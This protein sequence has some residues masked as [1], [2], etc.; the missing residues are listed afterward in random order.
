MSDIERLIAETLS[1]E[2]HIE[3]SAFFAARTMSAVRRE[4]EL[5]PLPFPM[6]RIATL[7]LLL[8]IVAVTGV[9]MPAEADPLSVDHLFVLAV[10]VTMMCAAAG[11]AAF[12]VRSRLTC[13][14]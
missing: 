2:R 8:V 6:K 4:A 13:H 1:S 11:A 9:S 7:V 10:L 14:A 3:P 5:P 12:E